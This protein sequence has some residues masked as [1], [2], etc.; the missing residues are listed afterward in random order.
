[1]KNPVEVIVLIK[2]SEGLATM[3]PFNIVEDDVE[4]IEDLLEGLSI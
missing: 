4:Q 1:M 3:G 2:S